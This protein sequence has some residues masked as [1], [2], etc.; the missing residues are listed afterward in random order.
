MS[1]PFQRLALIQCRIHPGGVLAERIRGNIR[2][3]RDA[4][5]LSRPQLARRVTPPTSSQQIER[6]EKGQR[7]LT[8]EWVEKIAKALKID[9]S[10]LLAPEL[11]RAHAVISLDEQVADEVARTLAAAATGDPDPAPGIVQALSLMLRELIETF[12]EHPQA[13]S[14]VQVARPVVAIA[15][16]RF[17]PAAS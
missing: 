17:A 2:R 1:T 15:G 7:K 16:K 3:A 14:D 4:E 6:L 13:A 9:P 5:G 11:S 8:L 10:D 12:S